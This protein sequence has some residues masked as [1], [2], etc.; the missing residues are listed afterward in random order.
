MDFHCQPWPLSLINIVAVLFITGPTRLLTEVVLQ[1][2]RGLD[3]LT[4]EKG[5]LC[6]FLNEDAAFM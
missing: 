6:L 2:R 1:I 4:A 3:L 5:G